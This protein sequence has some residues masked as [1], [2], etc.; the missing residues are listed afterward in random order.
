[1]TSHHAASTF[2]MLIVKSPSAPLSVLKQKD[3]GGAGTEKKI[4]QT[5]TSAISYFPVY[6]TAP[7]TWSISQ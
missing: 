3:A 4:L 5:A 1:M 6:L 2:T 7:F